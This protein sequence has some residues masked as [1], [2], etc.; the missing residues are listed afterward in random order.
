MIARKLSLLLQNF[1]LDVVAYDPFVSEEDMA[2]CG[3]T[4]TDLD[5]VFREADVVSVHTPAMPET[6]KLLNRS[7]FEKMKQGATLINTARGSVIDEEALIA[8]LGERPDLTA[9]LDVTSPEP[10]AEDSP[11]FALPNVILTPHIAG[12]MAGE[13]RRM[14]QYTI[15]ECKRYLAG[16]PLEWQITRESAKLMA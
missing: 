15:N 7:H 1:D 4:K 10:P 5:K 13:C 2:A 14:G 3:V 6:E 8:V 16:K 9:V 11:L 12:S